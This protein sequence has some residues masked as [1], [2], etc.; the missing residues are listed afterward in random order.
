MLSGKGLLSIVDK[1]EL[2]NVDLNVFN[3]NGETPLSIAIKLRQSKSI[4]WLIRHGALQDK[5]CDIDHCV[6]SYKELIDMFFPE[7]KYN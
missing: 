3:S 2:I 6:N 5:V 7:Y 4:D 1:D